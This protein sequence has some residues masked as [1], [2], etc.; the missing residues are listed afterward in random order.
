MD[1]N[2]KSTLLPMASHLRSAGAAL[3]EIGRQALGGAEAGNAYAKALETLGHNLDTTR[4]ALR[5]TVYAAA[6]S[7]MPEAEIARH[8]G[9]DRMTVRK[10]LG[11]QLKRGD[12]VVAEPY[13]DAPE[14]SELHSGPITGRYVPRDDQP[15]ARPPLDAAW[16]DD[17]DPQ[18]P[19]MV[20]RETV[21]QV[22][23]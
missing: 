21:R 20:K 14:G 19:Q 1:D 22:K 15:Q 8:A 5:Y 10:W 16:V 3:A 6:D 4:R 12:L 23:G 17:G 9:V 18:G 13:Y 2:L 11:K 7:G